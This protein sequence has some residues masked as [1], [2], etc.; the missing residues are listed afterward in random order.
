MN[1]AVFLDRDGVLNQTILRDGRPHPPAN[2]AELTLLPGVVEACHLLRDA[3]CRLVM[4]TN[5]PDI[6]R[7]TQ[8]RARVDEMN[9]HLHQALAL[10]AVYVCPHD[11]QDACACRKPKPGLLTAAAADLGIDLAHSFL[12]GDRWRDIDAGRAAGVRTVW[13]DYGYAEPPARDP[14]CT[15]QSLRQ[16]ADWIVKQP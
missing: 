9:A 8:T 2:L 6:G 3:G 16:A 1:R 13:I 10:D 11:D 12:V 15:V 14:D 4:V 7:G 5:Q